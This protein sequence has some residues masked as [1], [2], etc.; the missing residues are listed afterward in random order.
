TGALS[1]IT[2]AGGD[3]GGGGGVSIG[4]R[5]QTGSSSK[6]PKPVMVTGYDTIILPGRDSIGPVVKGASSKI[7]HDPA[8]RDMFPRVG[9]LK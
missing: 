9:E 7:G 4:K 1:G 6:L 2:S 5:P 3:N 8:G